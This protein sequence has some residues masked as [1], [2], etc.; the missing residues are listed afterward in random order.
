[1]W[2]ER[3]GEGKRTCYI[4]RGRGG[5]GNKG[6]VGR[7]EEYG[8][9]KLLPRNAI[10]IPPH[11][12][13]PLRQRQ[14][15]MLKARRQNSNP[16]SRTTATSTSATAK[17]QPKVKKAPAPTDESTP[18]TSISTVPPGRNAATQATQKL[19]DVIMPDRNSFEQQMK[20]S[21]KSGGGVTGME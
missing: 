16:Q 11:A 2:R 18:T 20:K 1:M 14:L 4:C 9:S 17:P 12:H 21:Q 3:E 8:V 10:T 7:V 6:E 15:Q 13:L 5:G 19:H